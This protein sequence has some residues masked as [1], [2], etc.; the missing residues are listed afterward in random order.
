MNG[1]RIIHTHNVYSRRVVKCAAAAPEIPSTS[2]FVHWRGLRP[3]P[4]GD[5]GRDRA[6]LTETKLAF[7]GSST[8]VYNARG[9]L[10]SSS[11]PPRGDDVPIVV[12]IRYIFMVSV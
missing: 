11:P 6:K 4:R 5:R 1:R 7:G 3:S 10:C 9:N 8:R 12:Y 2:S